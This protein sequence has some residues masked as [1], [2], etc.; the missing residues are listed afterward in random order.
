MVSQGRL[1]TT[2]L[3]SL[4]TTLSAAERLRLSL[5]RFVDRGYEIDVPLRGNPK[6]EFSGA[7]VI[8]YGKIASVDDVH[9]YQYV[10]AREA[11]FD[12][13]DD[14]NQDLARQGDVY[15]VSL[16]LLDA[17]HPANLSDAGCN[18]ATSVNHLLRNDRTRRARIPD[19]IKCYELGRGS[20]LSRIPRKGDGAL[21]LEDVPQATFGRCS[22]GA[23][24][25]CYENTTLE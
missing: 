18:Q 17:M 24:R 8:R 5:Y 21:I 22:K 19:R 20:T 15:Q 23:A 16:C 6:R 14:R 12:D 25:P 3:L 11:T 2:S 7:A 13:P 10:S 9:A 4:A 1:A